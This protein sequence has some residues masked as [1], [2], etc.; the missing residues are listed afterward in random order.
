MCKSIT[1]TVNTKATRTILRTYQKYQFRNFIIIMRADTEKSDAFDFDDVDNIMDVINSVADM[2][3]NPNSP[4]HIDS[5]LYLHNQHTRYSV[6]AVATSATDDAP[7]TP[8]SSPKKY[9]ITP[10]PGLNK[11]PRWSNKFSQ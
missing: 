11:V 7:K 6:P 4:A 2:D 9:R 10:K 5:H 8:S 3:G 1:V